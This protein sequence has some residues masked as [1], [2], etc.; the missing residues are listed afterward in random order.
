V[1]P[2]VADG[3]YGYPSVNVT[4]AQRDADSLLR[5]FQHALH[6]LRECPEVGSGRCT[7]LPAGDPAVLVHRMDA[8]PGSLLFLHN[9][10]RTDLR[11][12]VGPPEDGPADPVELFADRGYAAPGGQLTGLELGGCGYR[13]IRL[14]RA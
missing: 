8:G 2:V 9:L 5:W 6:T 3:R 14:R 13:W 12:D 11:V 4:D 7:P 1:R 10:G